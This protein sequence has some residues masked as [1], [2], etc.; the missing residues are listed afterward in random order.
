M[1]WKRISVDDRE[2]LLI[3]HN[4]RFAT[5]LRPGDYWF[6]MPCKIEIERHDVR[7]LV[8]RSFWGPF[9]LDQRPELVDRHFVRVETSET[10]VGLVYVNGSLYQVLT[11]AKRLLFWRDAAAVSAEVV[12]V[13]S[14]YV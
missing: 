14:A 12:D 7:D 4:G 9:L 1:H 10:Q 5:I 3:T 8:F 6:R 2:R 11:P 13:I